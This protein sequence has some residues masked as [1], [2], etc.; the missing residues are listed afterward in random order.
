MPKSRPARSCRK[1][2]QFVDEEVA[3]HGDARHV[4]DAL[5][6]GVLAPLKE[7]FEVVPREGAVWTSRQ[8]VR[9]QER[10]EGRA[11]FHCYVI[12]VAAGWTLADALVG[13]AVDQRS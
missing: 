10:R 9:A 4:L 3:R 7:A 5:P 8:D 12:Q 1:L 13:L 11:H 2:L 6:D